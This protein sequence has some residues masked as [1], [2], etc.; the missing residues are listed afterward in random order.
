M[1]S[2][3]NGNYSLKIKLESQRAET[4]EKKIFSSSTCPRQLKLNQQLASK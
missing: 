1:S 3:K 4:F 2:K